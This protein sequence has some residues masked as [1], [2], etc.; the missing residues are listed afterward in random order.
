MIS[1]TFYTDQ[2][3]RTP[4]ISNYFLFPL[5]V[6]DSGVLLY[7]VH[8]KTKDE[9]QCQPKNGVQ[10]SKAIKTLFLKISLILT[11]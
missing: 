6:R 11:V 7:T 5:R 8:S 9:Q 3:S 1:L 4:A 10:Y 2:L